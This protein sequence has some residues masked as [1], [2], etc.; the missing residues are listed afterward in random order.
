VPNL[1]IAREKTCVVFF[2]FVSS[3]ALQGVAIAA[4]A[5]AAYGADL[6]QATAP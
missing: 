4:P 3:T 2:G 5:A 1:Q 6:I